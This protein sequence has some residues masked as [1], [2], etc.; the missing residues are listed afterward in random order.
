MFEIGKYVKLHTNNEYN[1]HY[2]LIDEI[3]SDNLLIFCVHMPGT[4]YVV[5]LR[6]AEHC[7]ELVEF[8]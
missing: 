2:G 4:R 3:Y 1:N 8:N 7:L 5:P 6:E